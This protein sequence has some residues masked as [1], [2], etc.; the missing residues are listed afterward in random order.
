MS[1]LI[2][3]TLLALLMAAPLMLG[4]CSKKGQAPGQQPGT[5]ESEKRTPSSIRGEAP[6]TAVVQKKGGSPS[7]YPAVSGTLTIEKPSDPAA[8]Q[9]LA[10]PLPPRC[11]S[12][13]YTR[14]VRSG[15]DLSQ[16]RNLLKLT[17]L[18]IDQPINPKSVC[19]RVNGIPVKH[20]AILSKGKAKELKGLILDPIANPKAAI[21]ATFCM[22]KN[23]CSDGCK[24]P[25]DEF[26]DAIGGSDAKGG[27]WDSNESEV[28]GALDGRL[29]RELE[30]GS[31]YELSDRW[32]RAEAQPACLTRAEKA[33]M[34]RTLANQRGN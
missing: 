11:L 13:T 16:S 12:A 32:T 19:V 21:T 25:R 33:Q 15:E 14:N 27:S 2:N 28:L 23:T 8:K 1:L 9:E 29:K 4:A 10:K 3:R 31:D 20:R 18:G 6:E 26:M 5:P 34:G 17:D 22:G 24:I 7:H 30:A